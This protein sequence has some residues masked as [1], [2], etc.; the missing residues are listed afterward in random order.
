M[1]VIHTEQAPSHTGPVPQAV[2]SGGWIYVSAL[3]GSDPAT[4]ELP[5]DPR[6][7]AERIFANLTA[8]LAAADASLADV[9]RVSIYMKNLQRDRPI[10]N[11]VWTSY[12]G[13]HRPA[14]SAV[15]VSD[16]GRP[17]EAVHYMIEAVAHRD[18]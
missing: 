1:K 9:V 17:R 2:E 12:F 13:D 18:G 8:I 6:L 16:F 4:G 3:F 10:F 11:E 15:E 7:E 14:R 5:S